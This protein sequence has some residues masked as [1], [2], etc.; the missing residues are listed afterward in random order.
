MVYVGD[1]L[2]VTVTH[3]QR[4]AKTTKFLMIKDFSKRRSNNNAALSL[5]IN[6]KPNK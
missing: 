5:I 1:R 6:I 3:W 4:M 2:N